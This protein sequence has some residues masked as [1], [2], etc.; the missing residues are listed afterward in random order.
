MKALWLEDHQLDLRDVPEPTKA[1]EALVRIRRAGICSTDLELV[2]GYYPFTGI[3]G[4]EF[5]GEV[6]LA[7]DHNWI[8]QRVVGNINVTC[9][10]CEQ[11]L[12]GR[13]THCE[14][15]T[16]LGISGR[17]G[18]FAEFTTLPLSNLCHVPASVPDDIAVFTEHN[19]QK[20]RS[21]RDHRQYLC[22]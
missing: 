20:D 19:Y 16:T 5:V 12:N 3:L 6:I 18:V 13:S 2:K 11:C 15:R 22:I 9:G 4:H 10:R 8:G 7:D 17:D 14:K 21:R 1:G